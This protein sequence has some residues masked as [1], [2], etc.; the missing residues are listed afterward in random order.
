MLCLF[1]GENGA[2]IGHS[3]LSECPLISHHLCAFI[4]TLFY[5]PHLYCMTLFVQV[6]QAEAPCPDRYSWALS[7]AL[8]PD[9]RRHTL[10]QFLCP[11]LSF[12]LGHRDP[13]TVFVFSAG[14]RCPLK[15]VPSVCPGPGT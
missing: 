8:T 14:L 3:C 15:R 13:G 10:F 1:P 11:D 6:F 5:H 2:L 12:A 4:W 9:A 7:P